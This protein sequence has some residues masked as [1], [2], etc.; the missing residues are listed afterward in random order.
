MFAWKIE[1]IIVLHFFIYHRYIEKILDEIFLKPNNY[2]GKQGN[3]KPYCQI[4]SCKNT[5]R[6]IKSNVLVNMFDMFD[7][8]FMWYDKYDENSI[9]FQSSIIPI[10]YVCSF[11]D[12]I[13]R[14][15][16]QIKI[17]CLLFSLFNFQLFFDVHWFLSG[18]NDYY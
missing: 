6:N 7:T 11:I 4:Q 1:T 14:E 16:N 9:W 12:L 3:H 15:I 2:V 18:N 5:N 17:F 10:I 13:H 8:C